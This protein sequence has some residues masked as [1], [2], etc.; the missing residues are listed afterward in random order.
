MPNDLIYK[1]AVTRIPKVGGVTAK[2]L[3]S[4]CGGAEAVFR[5]KKRELLKIPGIGPV[6]ADNILTQTV[7]HEAEA[8]LEWIEQHDIQPIF[9]LDDTYPDR[10]RLYEDAPLMLYYKGNADLNA[11]RIVSIVGTRKPT[12]RGK[13]ICTEIVAGLKDY[14]VLIVSGLAYGIDVTAHRKCLEIGVPTVG[15]LGHG[16]DQIYPAAHRQVGLDMCENGGLLTEFSYKAGPNREHFPMRNRIIA[17]M[18]D[19]LIVVES[20]AGGGSIISAKLGNKYNKSVFA[21]PGR[22]RDDQSKG[23]NGLIKRNK[24]HLLE[25]VEDVAYIMEW[26]EE[27]VP[28]PAVQKQLFIDLTENEQAIV[29]I[30]KT[31]DEVGIDMITF[32]AKMYPAQVSSLLLNLE[33]KG[34]VKSLPGKR[35]MLTY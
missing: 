9:Y 1:M 7:L 35:Y 27:G 22:L 28:K 30:L 5:A 16:L 24:A 12:E 29:N 33:F 18:S 6:I 19:A 4:Y 13:A 11:A 10:M 34:L 23:C 3:I 2:N 14:D 8:E 21:V 25:S 31:A 20:G 32:E 17:G 26:M 15:I